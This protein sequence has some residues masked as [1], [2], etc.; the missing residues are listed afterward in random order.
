MVTGGYLEGAV[1]ISNL[2]WLDVIWFIVYFYLI[3]Y[4][5]RIWSLG[6]TC[7]H[8]HHCVC[9]RYLWNTAGICSACLEHY[10]N[11]LYPCPVVCL[12]EGEGRRKPPVIVWKEMIIYHPTSRG[13]QLT[14]PKAGGLKGAERVQEGIK[15]DKYTTKYIKHTKVHLRKVRLADTR[16]MLARGMTHLKH[17]N[18]KFWGHNGQRFCTLPSWNMFVAVIQT[19]GGGHIHPLVRMLRCRFASLCV[20]LCVGPASEVPRW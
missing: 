7:L 6:T 2:F 17:L 9:R 16:Q 20:R 3:N 15:C 1:L 8:C 4:W 10:S 5:I 18:W 11:L 19:R 12:S 13:D 14:G